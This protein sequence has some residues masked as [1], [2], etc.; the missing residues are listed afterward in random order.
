MR[1]TTLHR[2]ACTLTTAT[3]SDAYALR[4]S[5]IIKLAT[6]QE[7][8]IVSLER[9]SWLAVLLATA[10]FIGFLQPPAGTTVSK[11]YTV[12][13][14]V[15]ND[16]QAVDKLTGRT[17]TDLAR[18]LSPAKR[19]FLV[20]DTWSFLLALSCL[21]IIV[22]LSMPRLKSDTDSKEAG[23]FWIMLVL[24][25]GQLYLAV[26]TGCGAFVASALCLYD[27]KSHIWPPTI[28]GS[29]ILLMGCCF[30]LQRFATLSP[31]ITAVCLGMQEIWQRDLP[32][33]RIPG[34]NR[35]L[36]LCFACCLCMPCTAP[37]PTQ[38]QLQ[39]RAPT[40]PSNSMGHIVIPFWQSMLWSWHAVFMRCGLLPEDYLV[41]LRDNN[42]A[43]WGDGL[44]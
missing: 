21:V 6:E 4:Y 23:R 17:E 15:G 33:Y 35:L 9:M 28:I 22:V 18:D 43:K 37:A 13:V 38:E 2:S 36:R 24:A 32:F 8:M 14:P 1:I 16:T 39:A 19:L 10:T 25:W 27:D 30:I 31:G 5:N 29:T 12:T 34:V 11:E 40:A 7:V 20:L 42:K 41:R 44:C 26:A 3:L